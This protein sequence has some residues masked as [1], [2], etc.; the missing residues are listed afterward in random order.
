MVFKVYVQQYSSEVEMIEI[1]QLYHL[2]STA[3]HLDV[4]IYPFHYLESP[5]SYCMY[6]LYGN[7]YIHNTYI[8][9]FYFII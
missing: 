4:Y 1:Y 2:A 9:S 7:V 8:T 6:I 3:S 5:F